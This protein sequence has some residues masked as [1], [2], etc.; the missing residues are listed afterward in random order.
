MKT[1]AKENVKTEETLRHTSKLIYTVL[2]MNW[3]GF[4]KVMCGFI[5]IRK[6][7]YRSVDRRS[8]SQKICCFNLF[9]AEIHNDSVLNWFI[10][11]SFKI[12][13]LRT[14]W[15]CLCVRFF[16]FVFVWFFFILL[17]RLLHFRI[18]RLPSSF[19]V[20][21]EILLILLNYPTRLSLI[22]SRCCRCLTYRLE[23]RLFLPLRRQQ[24]VL[25]LDLVRFVLVLEPERPLVVA[26]VVVLGRL[27]LVQLELAMPIFVLALQQP[28]LVVG[29][30]QIR[31]RLEPLFR[32]EKKKKDSSQNTT[33]LDFFFVFFLLES[34]NRKC[35]TSNLI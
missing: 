23:Q 22:S 24:L 28:L 11:L 14:G 27:E 4:A 31:W 7:I 34:R 35:T 30:F 12:I 25:L 17:R 29:R 26:V 13:R 33:V 15:V 32:N 19:L 20:L 5:F 21:L 6:S 16:C 3:N 1:Y 8:S 18:F 9:F 10:S 2:K